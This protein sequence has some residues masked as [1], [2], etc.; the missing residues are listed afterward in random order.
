VGQVLLRNNTR[1]LAHAAIQSA[2]WVAESLATQAEDAAATRS[3]ALD[4]MERV[5]AQTAADALTR[6]TASASTARE[7]TLV[8]EETQSR[9]RVE[10]ETNRRERGAMQA[11]MRGEVERVAE[12]QRQAWG[13]VLA[14]FGG[15][16]VGELAALDV[17]PAEGVAVVDALAGLAEPEPEE[18]FELSPTEAKLRRAKEDAASAAAKL[19]AFEVAEA[20]RALRQADSKEEG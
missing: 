16:E 17:S 10:R 20:A 19:K 12:E 18:G 3:Q 9:L 1:Q 2:R 7:L 8:L 15:A 4:E 13:T 6:G 11:A 5:V 14:C